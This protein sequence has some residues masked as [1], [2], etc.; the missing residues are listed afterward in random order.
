MSDLLLSRVA[1]PL[2]AI[3][4]L[5]YRGRFWTERIALDGSLTAVVIDSPRDA[6]RYY[7]D[8]QDD[9]DGQVYAPFPMKFG[10][11]A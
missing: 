7:L 1:T 5:H 4:E 2:G 9:P 10:A 11:V 6:Y 3:L 8:A